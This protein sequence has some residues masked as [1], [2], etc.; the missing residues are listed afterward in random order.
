MID[1]KCE[2]TQLDYSLSFSDGDDVV[3]IYQC[4]GCS[5]RVTSRRV[6]AYGRGE[7]RVPRSYVPDIRTRREEPKP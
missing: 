6:G 1:N 7:Q 5:E 3:D 2:H 4:V